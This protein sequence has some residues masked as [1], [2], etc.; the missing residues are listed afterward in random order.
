VNTS[1][2]VTERDRKSASTR[3]AAQHRIKRETAFVVGADG[4]QY[5]VFVVLC[6]VCGGLGGWFEQ[7]CADFAARDHIQP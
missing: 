6:T 1:V 4:V 3:R 2:S 7:D 5:P